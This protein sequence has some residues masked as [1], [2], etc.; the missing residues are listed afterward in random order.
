[1]EIINGFSG[2]S[3]SLQGIQKSQMMMN[4]SAQNVATGEGDLAKETVNQI[5][6]EKSQSA[7]TETVRTK[8]EMLEELMHMQK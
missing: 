2:F 1:M 7:N 6:A 5:V 4:K 8:D 3:T